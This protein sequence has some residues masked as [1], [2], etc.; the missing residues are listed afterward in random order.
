MRG[1]EAVSICAVL[2]CCS[3]LAAGV[4]VD[5]SLA[6]KPSVCTGTFCEDSGDP[7]L[8]L[9]L[10]PRF[11]GYCNLSN[12]VDCSI[13]D[14]KEICEGNFCT[15]NDK[16]LAEGLCPHQCGYCNATAATPTCKDHLVNGLQCSDIPSVCSDSYGQELCPLYCNH[17]SQPPG[18]VECKDH[19]THHLSCADLPSL[20]SDAYYGK[21]LCPK[22]C[23]LCH[24]SQSTPTA[25]SQTTQPPSAAVTTSSPVMPTTTLG[26]LDDT[27][28]DH[29]GNGVACSNILNICN[30]IYGRILCQRTCNICVPR[31]GSTSPPVVAQ[32]PGSCVDHVIGHLTCAQLPHVCNDSLA[33][34]FCPRHCHVCGTTPT[35]T[36]ASTGDCSDNVINGLNC[37]EIP[38]VCKNIYGVLACR[39]NC[40]RCNSTSTVT[41][42]PSDV[43]AAP[44]SCVDRVGNGVKCSE[45][46]GVCE[47]TQLI[48]PNILCLAY[49]GTCVPDSTTPSSACRDNIG[50]G[51]TCANFTDI[52]LKP[53]AAQVCPH[54]C[55]LCGTATTSPPATTAATTTSCLN[56]VGDGLSCG[57]LIRET[58]D[59]CQGA[60]AMLVCPRACN[61]CVTTTLL[62]TQSSTTTTTTTT[63]T[64]TTP[65]TNPSTTP[66]VMTSTT[67]DVTT[68]S[69]QPCLDK[70]LAGVSCADLYPTFGVDVC[71]DANGRKSCPVFCGLCPTSPTAPATTD[72]NCKPI[73]GSAD[74]EDRAEFAVCNL[75]RFC[76]DPY[77][78]VVCRK[79]CDLCDRGCEDRLITA[80][81]SC[82]DLYGPGK[83]ILTLDD[84]CNDEL[85]A[86]VCEKTC[87]CKNYCKNP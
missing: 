8:A 69:A 7:E 53:F 14:R 74:C 77:A 26:P 71:N 25:Q 21:R 32:P 47:D 35:T 23:N 9:T 31:P 12:S 45:L 48:G 38:D 51:E 19:I 10:C 70:Q 22:S 1:L 78:Q 80:G 37:Q 72:A 40:G 52:C 83:P 59:F 62:T 79:T 28:V 61:R 65:P 85:G 82:N 57:Q 39:K 30:D 29:I 46:H 5:C 27:C 4:K 68:T 63:T 64:P 41:P 17:C 34:V 76:E 18:S 73:N 15:E 36:A 86:K 3:P 42:P 2:M 67:T 43:T 75:H 6:E 54:F 11:C 84:L 50:E 66:T 24:S 33:K 58:P 16:D 56:H 20:C 60:Y 87:N 44:G 13:P 81:S 55:G 49:C